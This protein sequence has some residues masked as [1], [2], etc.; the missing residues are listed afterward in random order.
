MYPGARR[1]L[2]TAYADTN[3]AIDAINVV[4]LDHYLLK[5]WDPPEEKLYPVLDDLLDAWRATRTTG[6]CRDTKVVGHRWS[7]RSFAR[8]GV[9]GPQPG[10]LPLVLLADEPEGRGCWPPPAPDGQRLPLV[11]TADGAV[12]G[13]ARRHAS[14][15]HRWGWPRPRRPTST[16]SSSSAAGPAGLGAAVYGA[17]EGLRTVL[18]ERSA[19]GGQAGQSCRI[20][21]Y[22]GFPDGVSGAQLT[23]RARRQAL[24]FGAEIL[25]AR[26]VVRPGG[27]PAPARIVR[28]ADGS[29]IAAHTRDPGDRRLLPA[30]RRPR[31]SRSSPARASST[32]PP[33]PRRPPARARTS[34]S[35]AAPTPRG[36]RRCTCRGAPSRSPAGARRRPVHVD[37]ALPDRADRG[38][39]RT[40]A[41]TRG[42]RSSRRRTA[43]TTCEQLTLRDTRSGSTERSTRSGCSCSSARPR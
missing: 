33:S 41:S 39:R 16:T 42:P 20:E 4:D 29:A 25:T 32:D 43:P 36:R 40:S 37:V 12:A 15:P 34:T 35:S 6:R 38:H 2:L 14:W 5:P 21:N 11:I 27:Q 7:A 1:V 19:T 26:E 3:A 30:A 9:P 23:D 10:A 13:R 28:F 18:V 31:D 8:T 24:K 22:L 17:S